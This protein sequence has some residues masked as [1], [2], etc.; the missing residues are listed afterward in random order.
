MVQVPTA[1]AFV[2]SNPHLSARP[3]LLTFAVAA[4]LAVP[5]AHGAT[6]TVY[7][8]GDPFLATGADCTL[9]GAIANANTDS[10]NSNGC[11][12]GS[13]ADTIE[14]DASVT[15]T[16]ILSSSPLAITDDLTISGPG[17]R[18]LTI[19][20][21]ANSRVLDIADQT[22]VTVNALTIHNGSTSGS[23]GGIQA[24]V[25]STLALTN[26]TVSGNRAREGGGLKAYSATLTD[27]TV[28]ENRVS[29]R[30]GGT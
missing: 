3:K 10:N 28:S 22:V 5:A 23:G 17:A 29:D 6:I 1:P 25:C 16:I 2:P 20:G 24:G 21:N 4:V 11:Q 18:A 30:G 7:T 19:D 15:G 9:R 26:S 14:F 12:A 8:P 27:S 13:G